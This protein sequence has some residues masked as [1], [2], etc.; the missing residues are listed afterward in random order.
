[1]SDPGCD[2][3]L[4]PK[5]TRAVSALRSDVE[6]RAEWRE[7]LLREVAHRPEATVPGVIALPRHHERRWSLSPF[8]AIAAGLALVALGAA[9]TGVVM[10]LGQ[11]N[12]NDG[13]L[14]RATETASTTTGAMTVTAVATSDAR[15]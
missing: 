11:P 10:R 9:G 8:A 6:V 12:A 2:E 15:S 7:A 13:Q 14:A 4:H 3:E 5:L 1:M